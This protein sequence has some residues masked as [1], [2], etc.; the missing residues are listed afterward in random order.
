MG[1]KGDKMQKGSVD[2]ANYVVETLSLVSDIS[3]KKM[4][5][6]HGIFYKGNMFGMVNSKGQV[7][8]KANDSNKSFF[9]ENGSEKH[10][11]MPYYSIP[12]EVFEDRD[13]LID[14][15]KKSIA[16]VS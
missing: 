15:S 5:G 11:K 8:L 2:A 12:D 4:F 7:Y 1:I 9:E 13:R 14:W 3:T 16:I 10:S 6:G